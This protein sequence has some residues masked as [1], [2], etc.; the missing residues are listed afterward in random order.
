MMR[1]CVANLGHEMQIQT[2]TH[3]MPDDCY[4]CLI[5]AKKHAPNDVG[6]VWVC[7]RFGFTFV[8]CP[9]VGGRTISMCFHAL[10][11]TVFNAL[12]TQF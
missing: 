5:W 8:I 10:P 3:E 6:F 2:T 7:T 12:G 1:A 11:D 9:T 4:T